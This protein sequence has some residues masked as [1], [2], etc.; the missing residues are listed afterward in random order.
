MIFSV[1]S[2]VRKSARRSEPGIET[3]ND[4]RDK[5]G[6]HWVWI[7]LGGGLALAIAVATLTRGPDGIT[8]VGLLK[9]YIFGETP[10]RAI[11]TANYDFNGT[12]PVITVSGWNDEFVVVLIHDAIVEENGVQDDHV[13][14][15][16]ERDHGVDWKCWRGSGDITI[17]GRRMNVRRGRVFLVRTGSGSFAVKQLERGNLTSNTRACILGAT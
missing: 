2:G 9:Q 7:A 13:W 8:I 17:G 14:G 12:S 1:I 4:V 10:G 6:K 16:L 15:Y 3:M 11:H 5:L